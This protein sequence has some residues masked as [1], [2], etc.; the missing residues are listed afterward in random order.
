MDLNEAMEDFE[1][2]C[3]GKIL[4]VTGEALEMV[5]TAI[6]E[7]QEYRAIGKRSIV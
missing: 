2:F 3:K 4:C 7:V 5:R 1:M 6:R